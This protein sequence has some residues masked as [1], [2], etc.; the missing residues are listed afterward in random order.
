[1][2]LM[3]AIIYCPN[4]RIRNEFFSLLLGVQLPEKALDFCLNFEYYMRDVVK[5]AEDCFLGVNWVTLGY[6]A[7]LSKSR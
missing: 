3:Q 5:K 4:V 1:M 6:F 2:E 7:S